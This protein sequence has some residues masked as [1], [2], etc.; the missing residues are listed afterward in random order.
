MR[1]SIIPYN[2]KF[3]QAAG[4]SRGILYEKESWFIV[5]ESNGIRGIGECSLIPGLSPEN[6]NLYESELDWLVENTNAIE[7]WISVKGNLFPS[8]KFGI[9]TA[10]ADLNSGGKQLFEQDEFTSGRSGIPINGLI[11]MGD[12]DF[13]RDQVRIK[14]EE[15]FHCIKIKVGAIDFEEEISLLK[16]IRK[17]FDAKTIEIRLDANGAFNPKT[18]M[19]KLKRLS[20]FDIHSIEQPIR[21]GLIASMTSLC[22]KSPIPVAL[23]EELI[24][25]YDKNRQFELLNLIKPA[26]I[27]LKP[28][29][30]GGLQQANQ[31][32]ALAE[33]LDVG[34]WATSALESNIG[35][36]VIAQWAFSTKNPMHQGL[37]TGQLYTNNFESPLEIRHGC[38]YHN[39]SASWNLKML[40][41]E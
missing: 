6:R 14:I 1:A 22:E 17:Q 33:S 40:Q 16:L 35:L 29:L 36:N 38:L 37:G 3:K 27:I 10:L 7:S 39:P 24:G 8:I 5:L 19:E 20:E 4:T 23:D 25:L 15:G 21:P 11:W 2:L 18:A 9:E 26:Y 34:W 32:I 30:I 31:W 28:S 41:T 13:M 12:A